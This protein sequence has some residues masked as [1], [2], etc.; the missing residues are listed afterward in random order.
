MIKSGPIGVLYW[1]LVVFLV[2]FGLLAIAS[3]G[4]PFLILGIAL[5]VLSP[6]RTRPA[7]FWPVLYGITGFLLGFVLVAPLFC[8][9][10]HAARIPPAP[11]AAETHTTC[12]SVVGIE[13]AGAGSYTPPVWPAVVA[14]LGVASTAWLV[15]RKVTKPAT[16]EV[17][18]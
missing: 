9:S 4:L 7:F 18:A 6:S 13:Y 14:G 10:S 17:K 11:A 12:N 1:Y 5:A 16:E 8:R 2:A 3:I 15:G